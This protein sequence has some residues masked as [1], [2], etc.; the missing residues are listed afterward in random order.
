[1]IAI[2]MEMPENCVVCQFDMPDGSCAAMP[3]NF[4]G[5]TA[6]SEL[7]RKPEWCPLIPIIETHY[8]DGQ[9]YSMFVNEKWRME[10][11]ESEVSKSD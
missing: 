1:M 7:E 10:K 3:I 9:V 2:D 4:C 11:I 8:K 6:Y 5:H